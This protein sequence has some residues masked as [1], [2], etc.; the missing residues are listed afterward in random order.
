MNNLC[1]NLRI[2]KPALFVVVIVNRAV[3]DL[4]LWRRV[5]LETGADGIILFS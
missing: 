4:F 2:E 1:V 3:N 5:A